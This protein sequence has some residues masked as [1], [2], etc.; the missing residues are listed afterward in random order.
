MPLLD[1]IVAD[2]R[3]EEIFG[4][5]N[6]PVL[7]EMIKGLMNAEVIVC[8]S[9]N[10]PGIKTRGDKSRTTE[11]GA[12]MKTGGGVRGVTAGKKANGNKNSEARKARTKTDDGARVVTASKKANRRKSGCNKK[13][14]SNKTGGDKKANGNKAGGN[15]KAN[16]PSQH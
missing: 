8:N 15:K 1:T 10:D 12:G 13:V 6:F 9:N 16:R 3:S 4:Q 2:S 5:D 14:N 11:S 7:L